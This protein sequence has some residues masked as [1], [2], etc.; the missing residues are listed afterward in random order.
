[1]TA[2]CGNASSTRADRFA[3]QVAVVMV[4]AE[5]DRLGRLG[6]RGA[7]QV[8]PHP[9]AIID[10]GA[11]LA[12]RARSAPASCRSA[13]PRYSWPSA[14][15]PRSARSGHSRPRSRWFRATCRARRDP[16]AL[17]SSR[18]SSQSV[19]RIRN[20]VAA[21]D[22]VTTAPNSDAASG[23]DQ[24]R[25]RGLREQHE[26]E[27][28]RLAEQQPEPDAA[29]P[30]IAEQRAPARRGSADLITIT[31]SAIPTTSNGRAAI[32]PRSSSIPTDRKNRPSRIERNGSTSLSSSWR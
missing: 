15:A 7:Q 9:V 13:S 8:D 24:L 6:P 5:Q 23:S 19:S 12:R 14:S 32:T 26:A 29:R 21:I 30:A 17:A 1:M 10:L 25:R 18:A 31:A 4:V 2:A 11:E 16:S 28:A 3:R 22:S 20:G 27:F